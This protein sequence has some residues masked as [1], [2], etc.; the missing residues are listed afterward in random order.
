MI[1][2]KATMHT[3][4]TGNANHN[5]REMNPKY[6][7]EHIDVSRQ[8]ENIYLS[9]KSLPFT[10]AEKE[11]YKDRYSAW[12]E[13]RNA[14]HIASGHKSR[15]TTTD[16]LLRAERTKPEEVILQIGRA[17]Q[18]VDKDVFASCVEEYLKEMQKYDSN[19][20]ILDVAIHNDEATPHCHIRRVWDYTDKDGNIKIGLT[21]ALRELEVPPPD[22]SLPDDLRF[23]NR[24]MTFDAMMREKWYEIVQ[25]HGIMLDKTPSRNGNIHMQKDELIINAQN[26]TIIANQEKIAQQQRELWLLEEEMKERQEEFKRQ[27]GLAATVA[28]ITAN[29]L[30]DLTGAIDEYNQ[31]M[32][33]EER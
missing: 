16:K 33:E 9:Y 29:A 26:E 8:H 24:K 19:M 5:D 32:M 11:F 31:M 4:K 1:T 27:N 17:G 18:T 10:E 7:D 21:G 6:Q 3:G 22:P 23:N 12:V 2:M 14:K 15:C 25:A 13:A 30:T 20:H 28:F